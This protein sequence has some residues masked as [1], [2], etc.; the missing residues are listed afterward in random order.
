MRM[1]LKE[2]SINTRNW[3]N[4]AQRSDYWRA[5]V[6]AAL[7]LWVPYAMEL[8]RY[9]ICTRTQIHNCILFHLNIYYYTK[10]IYKNHRIIRLEVSLSN[11]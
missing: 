4:F 6:N 9:I 2:I 10:S 7:N 11:Y 5:L 3:I 1:D 8:V